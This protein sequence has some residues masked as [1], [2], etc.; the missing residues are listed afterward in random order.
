MLSFVDM[1][2]KIDSKPITFINALTAYTALSREVGG[3][4]YFLKKAV[5]FELGD[6]ITDEAFHEFKDR[7]EWISQVEQKYA[8]SP[9]ANIF[10]ELGEQNGGIWVISVI[11]KEARQRLISI[12]SF[13]T[14]DCDSRVLTRLCQFPFEIILSDSD[15]FMFDGI[16]GRV[17]A[18]LG[19]RHEQSEEESIATPKR[20]F[21]TMNYDGTTQYL[22]DKYELNNAQIEKAKT[23]LDSLKKSNH[24]YNKRSAL[25]AEKKCNETLLNLTRQ[26]RD[27]GLEIILS[28]QK[29]R[30]IFGFFTAIRFLV[31][32]NCKNIGEYELTPPTLEKKLRKKIF[33]ITYKTLIITK[34]GKKKKA[35]PSEEDFL[36]GHNRVHLC[37][38][39]FKEYTED[40]PLLGKHVGVWWWSSHV[41][42]QN[43]DG[44][45]RKKYAVEELA[46]KAS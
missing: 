9:Y 31:L 1:A 16:V 15:F 17:G 21:K 22:E 4:E 32:L 14:D 10:V 24:L 29:K 41:R 7:D 18:S 36:F 8:F 20:F 12:I 27:I 5:V 39:H 26:S 6:S 30:T 35:D 3:E 46:E 33:G 28:L 45:I 43:K 13:G 38:G 23:D 11:D 25:I 34:S 40:A 19:N 37:R 42:G 44:E 2:E